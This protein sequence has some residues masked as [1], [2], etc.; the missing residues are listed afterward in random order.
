MAEKV[1]FRDSW[2]GER[3]LVI[4]TDTHVETFHDC[5]IVEGEIHKRPLHDEKIQEF[6]I[7]ARFSYEFRTYHEKK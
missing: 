5:R 1:E 7:P 4:T 3:D 2:D 6:V